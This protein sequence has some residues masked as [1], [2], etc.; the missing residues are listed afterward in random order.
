MLGLVGV[1]VIGYSLVLGYWGLG[2]MPAARESS[3]KTGALVV[4]L[5]SIAL[6]SRIAAAVVLPNAEQDGYSY[7]E[8]IERLTEHLKTGQFHQSD[9]YGFWLPA[10]QAASALVN[11]PIHEPLVA[12][13]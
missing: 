11:L 7:A 1:L 4:G 8:I 6:V 10:F 2:F 13:K 5:L 9:F 3:T 12:G